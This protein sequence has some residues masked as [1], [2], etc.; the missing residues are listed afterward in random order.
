MSAIQSGSRFGEVESQIDDPDPELSKIRDLDPSNF[1]ELRVDWW[2]N[3]WLSFKLC[4]RVQFKKV[5][6]GEFHSASE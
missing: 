1:A 2:V 5:F 4:L 6:V 3:R